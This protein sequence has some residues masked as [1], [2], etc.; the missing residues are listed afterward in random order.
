MFLPDGTLISASAVPHCGARGVREEVS[1]RWRNV[2]DLAQSSENFVSHVIFALSVIVT[3]DLTLLYHLPISQGQAA[4]CFGTLQVLVR[5]FWLLVVPYSF[6]EHNCSVSCS[7]YLKPDALSVTLVRRWDK[8][9][10]CCGSWEQTLT[11]PSNTVL[12]LMI[13]SHAWF[14]SNTR[15]LP[16]LMSKSACRTIVADKIACL[17]P[18]RHKA[19]ADGDVKVCLSYDIWW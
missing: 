1:R 17:I 15:P 18:I 13:R 5:Q 11:S 6:P 3:F 4:L 7:R 12:C 10:S 19:L 14:L 8:K 16:K 9:Y 2:V